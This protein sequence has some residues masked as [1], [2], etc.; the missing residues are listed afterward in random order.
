MTKNSI[1]EFFT[2]FSLFCIN[3]NII[4][5]YDCFDKIKKYLDL[6][7]ILTIYSIQNNNIIIMKYND[8]FSTPKQ[9]YKYILSLVPEPINCYAHCRDQCIFNTEIHHIIYNRMLIEIYL[10][11]NDDITCC[12]TIDGKYI[13]SPSLYKQLCKEITYIEIYSLITNYIDNKICEDALVFRTKDL[14]L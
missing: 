8:M 9:F 10:F 11:Y 6:D 2:K 3:E 7:K 5:F 12:I 1:V 4:I 14:K 13:H